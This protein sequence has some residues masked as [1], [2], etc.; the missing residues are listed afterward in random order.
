MVLGTSDLSNLST[1]H[2]VLVLTLFYKGAY[3][4]SM[5]IYQKALKQ[6]RSIVKSRSN[7]F[8]E[9]TNTK[10]LGESFL[11]LKATGAIDGVRNHDC[12]ILS[13]CQSTTLRNY[14]HVSYRQVKGNRRL[15]RVY[16][17]SYYQA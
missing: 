17:A 11:L 8:L 5:S 1:S 2:V 7:S 13:L 16:H 6:F 10:Q 4:T 9:P 15:T 14:M 12:V 3:L